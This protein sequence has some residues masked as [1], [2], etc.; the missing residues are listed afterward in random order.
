[1]AIITVS[2]VIKY[3]PLTA[4][5]TDAITNFIPVA[6]DEVENYCDRKF[7]KQ[8]YYEWHTGS[9]ILLTQYPVNQVKYIGTKE[10]VAEFDNDD[11]NYDITYNKTTN[12]NES[13]IVTDANVV[14]TTYSLSTYYNPNLLKT[15]I[16]LDYGA[17]TL[18]VSSGKGST[19]YKLFKS[20]T[21]RYIYAGDR[22]D[23]DTELIDNRTL[24]VSSGSTFLIIYSAG[25]DTADVPIDLKKATCQIVHDLIHAQND[26]ITGFIKSESL[27]N[28][29][30]VYA[31]TDYITQVILKYTKLLEPYVKK[32]I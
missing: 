26:D 32:S 9:E 20:G 14:S 2:D 10:I 12:A 8:D 21:G 29:S 17:I 15:Q 30:V 22:S 5:D 6:Q 13:L 1:M 31:D 23:V 27:T 4:L 16:E 18:S 19:S 24:K 7:D 11:Y 3:T 28:Y 25:W